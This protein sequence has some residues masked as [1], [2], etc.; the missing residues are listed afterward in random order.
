MDVKAGILTTEF[1]VTLL[2][3]LA[4][5]VFLFHPTAIAGQTASTVGSVITQVASF[6]VIIAS[7][8]SYLISRTNVKTTA[9]TTAAVTA[10]TSSAA[11]K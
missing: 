7:T 1:W 6:L 2:T 11:G 5:I 10:T 4:S 9:N 8:V 3:N